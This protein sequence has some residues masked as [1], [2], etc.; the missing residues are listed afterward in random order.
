MI[1]IF[2][3]IIII[4]MIMINDVPTITSNAGVSPPCRLQRVAVSHS[5]RPTAACSRVNEN[6]TGAF[7]GRALVPDGQEHGGDET[8]RV[9]HDRAEYQAGMDRRNDVRSGRGR[10]D[11]AAVDAG[12][13]YYR[14]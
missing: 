4:I 10:L 11:R 1:I 3:I 14:P 12:H 2:I 7:R 8:H 6:A 9:L 5:G 13:N